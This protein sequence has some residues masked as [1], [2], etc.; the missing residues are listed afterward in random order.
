MPVTR[1]WARVVDTG[2]PVSPTLRNMYSRLQLQ[3]DEVMKQVIYGSFC[4][5][6]FSRSSRGL[7]FI[8]S[9]PLLLQDTAYI[10]EMI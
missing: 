2:G 1:L 6:L 3:F 8:F 5:C 10:C 4:L 9:V 7:D